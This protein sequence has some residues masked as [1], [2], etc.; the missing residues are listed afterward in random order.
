MGIPFVGPL[1]DGI[2]GIGKSLIETKDKKNA[3]VHDENMADG[4][5]ITDMDDND[6]A[7]AIAKLKE[8]QGTIK[9]EVALATVLIP[10]WLA[11][12]KWD[13]FFGSSF[14]GPAVVS[15][16]MAALSGTPIW[17]QGLLTGAITGA[18]G[19][20]EYAKHQKRSRLS[21]SKNMVE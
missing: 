14:D 5:R 11:F 1:I 4:K 15:A 19:L 18:L 20:S 8:Q 9:D 21:V 12:A 16:G 7:Y 13:D 6:A 17:Y 3:R 10:A 2:V